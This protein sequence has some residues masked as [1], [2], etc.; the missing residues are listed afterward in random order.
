M[1]CAL[2]KEILGLWCPQ[3]TKL[4]ECNLWNNIIIININ[5]DPVQYLAINLPTSSNKRVFPNDMSHPG[6]RFVPHPA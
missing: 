5:V 2:N 3:L 6:H 4:S 1:Q